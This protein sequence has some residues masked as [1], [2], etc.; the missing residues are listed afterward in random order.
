MG[1]AHRLNLLLQ[2]TQELVGRAELGPEIIAANSSAD[3]ARG[4]A[5]LLTV[6]LLLGIRVATL[7]LLLLLGVRV[8]VLV[9]AALLLR[10]V[11][12]LLRVRVPASRL[13]NYAV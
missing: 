3:A 7:C 11:L 6:R 2:L 9:V 10:W 5:L 13:C 1:R 4:V 8:P 12:I